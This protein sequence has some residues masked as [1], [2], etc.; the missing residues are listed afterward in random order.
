MTR[1][2]DLYQIL[3]VACDGPG[4]VLPIYRE[5]SVKHLDNCDNSLTPCQAY[6]QL[7]EDSDSELLIYSHDDLTIHA[8][9]WASRVLAE[10]TS[11][12]NTVVVGLGGALA[13]GHPDMYKKP[14]VLGNMARYGYRSNQTDWQTHGELEEGSCRVAV[15]DAFFMAIRRDWLRTRRT[16]IP[17]PTGGVTKDGVMEY[18]LGWPVHALTHHLLD[19]WV[20]C[21]A[22]KDNKEVRMVG[23]SCTHHGGGSSTKPAYRE[24][25]W[26]QGGSLEEDHRQP[27]RWLYEAYRDVLPI[28]VNP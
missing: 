21:E 12:P 26:L 18:D 22:A 10:F 8:P 4:L 27:H 1:E 15:V 20:C 9:D 17:R 13:L 5:G 2:K 6:Q 3:S 19:L 16:L 28:Q 11:H 25:K 14:Y 24:A 23:V 7:L